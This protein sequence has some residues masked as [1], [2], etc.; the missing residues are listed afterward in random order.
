MTS[1]DESFL[2]ECAR[3]LI[4]AP[5]ENPPGDE[6][7]VASVIAKWCERA[8]LKTT[9]IET[10]PNRLNVLAILESKRPG[11]TIAWN[12]HIDVVPIVDSELWEHP[13]FEAFVDG[14]TLHGR[15]S[16]DMKGACAAAIAAAFTLAQSGGPSQGRLV[17]Q[18]VADEEVLGPHGTQ[19][20]YEQGFAN[21][22]AVIIGEPTDLEIAI[23][24]RGMLW[25]KATTHGIAAHGSVPHLGRSAIEEMARIVTALRTMSFEQSHP[26]LGAPSVNI[27]TIQGGSKTNIVP[28]ECT[29]EIDRR[30][31][32]VETPKSILSE[33]QKAIGQVNAHADF[34]IVR[35]AEPCEV[36]D[37]EEIVKL[38]LKE[39]EAVRGFAKTSA[40]TATTD[41][42]IL[43]GKAK[44]PTIIF[45][46]GSL[47][48]AHSTTEHVSIKELHE[49]ALI[50]SRMFESYLQ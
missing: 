14:D 34:E 2:L 9:L 47:G 13:P 49:A 44:I 37:N 1:I 36:S 50:Y 10:A 18:L 8:G 48:Q 35:W 39:C 5:S 46:P 28:A 38:A 19:A 45:G 22:D 16:A 29:I 6:R 21:A 43:L 25:V 31:L 4:R 30:T 42:Y 33:M 41:A 40:M 11:R 32:P 7:A 24:E 15:G 17:L 3:E 26:L 23:A 20:L 27:G 12:G